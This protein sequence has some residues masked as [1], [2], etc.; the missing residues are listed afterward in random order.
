MIFEW[1]PIY[2]VN[3]SE[4]DEQHKKMF[5]IL[6]KVFSEKLDGDVFLSNIMKEL[7]DYSLYH[8][9]TEEKYFSQFNYPKEEEHKRLHQEYVESINNFKK[10]NVK[11]SEL[12]DF[13]K[14][15]WFD[16]V[17]GADQEYS[18]FFNKNGLF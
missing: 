2:S 3:V 15:W 17:Q 11:E 13:L 14:N 4:I 7:D 12:K 18:I 10:N 1:L 5:D 6:N 8:F 16:H 9:E